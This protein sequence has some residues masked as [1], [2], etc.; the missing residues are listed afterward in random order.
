MTGGN[1]VKIGEVPAICQTCSDGLVNY[2]INV[3]I[4]R[5]L[6]MKAMT[7]IVSIGQVVPHEVVGMVITQKHLGMWSKDIIDKSHL[8]AYVW[9]KADGQRPFSCSGFDYAE[10]KFLSNLPCNIF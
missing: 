1:V 5:R 7:W 2:S 8:L 3:E 6:L 10:E 4:N 9:K